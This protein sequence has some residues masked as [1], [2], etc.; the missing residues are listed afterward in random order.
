MSDGTNVH[1]FID[2]VATLDLA[3]ILQESKDNRIKPCSESPYAAVFACYILKRQENSE[4]PVYPCPNFVIIGGSTLEDLKS[5]A[6][7]MLDNEFKSA[8]L[9]DKEKS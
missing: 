2:D 7:I 9:H 6:Q 4:D 8:S 1:K 3:A 5:K